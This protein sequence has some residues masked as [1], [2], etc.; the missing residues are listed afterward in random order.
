MCL[1]TYLSS[2]S[3]QLYG[4]CP[5]QTLYLVDLG[6]GNIV[7]QDTSSILYNYG[8]TRVK[9]FELSGFLKGLH[10]CLWRPRFGFNKSHHCENLKTN[11]IL[12]TYHF[13]SNSAC[14]SCWIVFYVLKNTRRRAYVCRSLSENKHL[15]RKPRRNKVQLQMM[16]GDSWR[17]FDTSASWEC[18]CLVCGFHWQDFQRIPFNPKF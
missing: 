14:Y 1:L 3:C 8:K 16:K 6:G 12:W 11:S 7:F 9:C 10:W 17:N 2:W 4:Q 5:L 15:S 13:F 18:V